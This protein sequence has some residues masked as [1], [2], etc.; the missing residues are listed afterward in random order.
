MENTEHISRI[1][2]SRAFWHVLFW[3]GFLVVYAVP[4]CSLEGDCVIMI[5]DILIL[6]PVKMAAV[7]LTIY[8][9]LPHYLLRKKYTYFFGL[10]FMSAII[11]GLVH[12]VLQFFIIGPMYYPETYMGWYFWNWS[13]LLYGVLNIYTI[14]AVATA[15]KLLKQSYENQRQTQQ[16][17]NEKLEAELKL[18]KAQ[19]HPHFLFNTLNNLYALALEQSGST[20][21]GILKLSNLLDYML[22]ECNVPMIALDKEIKLIDNYI[23]LEKLRYGQRLDVDFRV[24][25]NPSGKRIAPMLILPFVENSFKHGS[26]TKLAR[27]KIRI[28]LEVG[29][30]AIDLEVENA[31]TNQVT[32]DTQGYSE[33]IGLKNVR[34]RLD[35]LYPGRYSLEINESET[36]FRI[37]LNLEL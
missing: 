26:S 4:Y 34:R 2:N 3:I 12:R 28:D 17:A 7:Y 9:L 8:L 13:H 29:V 22:Y 37:R 30:N 25:G 11:F 10:F 15:I 36:T 18:L 35:L 16:L 23:E 21:E 14:V 31:R 1:K 5:F 33:G 6:M 24:S 32:Q 19:I 20:A 27:T